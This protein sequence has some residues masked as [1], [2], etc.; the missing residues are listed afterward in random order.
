[1]R[2][3]KLSSYADLYRNMFLAAAPYFQ[4]RF[5]SDKWIL[6]HFQP[7]EISVST[8]T[9]LVSM[10]ILSLLQNNASYPRRIILSLV[11]NI[12]IFTFL[13]LS[14][15]VKS[16]PQL[17]FGFLLLVIFGSSLST[18][19]IQNGV[20]SFTAGFGRKEYTQAIMTGQ[21]IAGVL[22]PLTQIISVAAVPAKQEGVDGGGQSPKAAF[23]YFITAT[24]VSGITLVAFF[25]LLR[26]KTRDDVLE[27]ARKYDEP[28]AAQSQ[29]A[30]ND[31]NK[32]K[33]V[34]L[35]HLFKKV[36]FLALGVIV[37][38]AVTMVFPVFTSVIL[39]VNGIN[40][41][42]FIPLGFLLWNI[43][44]LTGRL[45]T[46]S[47]RL[48]L[49][50]YPFALFC[51]GMARLLFI[52]LYFMCNIKGRGALVNSD[53]FY[54]IIVQLLFGI[55]NGYLGSSCMMGA[56]DWVAPDEREA[57]G[58]FMALCLMVGLTIGSLLSFTLGDI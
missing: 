30:T 14:T 18:G 58:G 4:R 42:I 10:A 43:G 31:E 15:F 32:K 26:Q 50:H 44:D 20:F 40:P 45:L 21:A 17:Y 35:V 24:L 48:L 5:D 16:S 41:A 22:P 27:A 47:P 29:P 54:L 57:I 9:N 13:A 1:M 55:S 49:T 56:G 19:F 8:I 39:S 36:P 46:L 34:S 38:F 53:F 3:A 52:P 33:S 28:N 11:L 12:V 7:A 6:N 51:F 2:V 23:I 25:Y 37:C